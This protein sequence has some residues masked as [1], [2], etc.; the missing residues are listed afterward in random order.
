M[1]GEE[2]GGAVAEGGG[3]EEEASGRDIE[4]I[5]SESFFPTFSW[6]MF[7][8]II[9]AQDYILSMQTKKM[10]IFFMGQRSRQSGE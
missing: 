9:F 1:D 3:D 5:V 8:F 7:Y 4:N 2:G 6:D 10:K